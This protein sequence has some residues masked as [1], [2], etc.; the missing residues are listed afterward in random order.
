MAPTSLKSSVVSKSR[1]KQVG[2]MFTRVQQLVQTSKPSM[3][4][5]NLTN[6]IVRVSMP[7]LIGD[8][9]PEKA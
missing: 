2:A 9:F 5:Q 7:S 8:S 1:A 4:T 6:A 3:L